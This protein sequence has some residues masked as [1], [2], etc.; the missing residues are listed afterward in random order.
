MTDVTQVIQ[1]DPASNECNQ[2]RTDE[3][4]C[5]V[6]PFIYLGKT[7]E[8]C[9]TVDYNNKL[10]CATTSNY[11]Q[12]K[13][14]GNCENA[15]TDENRF[16]PG[17]AYV[18]ECRKN[19]DYMLLY[20]KKSCKTCA[21]GRPSAC[22]D[23]N[24][25][26]PG[27]ASRGECEKNPN[28]MLVNCQ[29]SCK[30]C[31]GGDS[32]IGIEMLTALTALKTDGKNLAS[33]W[34]DN[35]KLCSSCSD[36]NG[37]TATRFQ[38]VAHGL[39]AAGQVAD[40]ISKF[41]DAMEVP[42]ALFQKLGAVGALFGAFS[43]MV[44]IIG[45]FGDSLEV[46]LLNKLLKTVNEGFDRMESRFDRVDDKLNRLVNQLH[47]DSFY[48]GVLPHVGKLQ[49][50]KINVEEYIQ[51]FS[52]C[53]DATNCAHL[54]QKRQDLERYDYV[55]LEESLNSI[56]R[57]FTGFI[58]QPPMCELMTKATE[59]DRLKV[60]EAGI[61]LYQHLIR[62]VADLLMVGALQGRGDA[63]MEKVK[64]T[65]IVKKIVAGMEKCDAN[66]ASTEWKNR[67]G[68]YNQPIWMDDM[69]TAIREYE[70][71]GTK[72]VAA[73]I[74][75][76]LSVKYFW[77]DW[78]VVVYTKMHGSD[79]H[80]RSY[81]G[82]EGVTTAD[83]RDKHGFDIL[84]SSLASTDPKNRFSGHVST[85][86]S[87][88][89][90]ANCCGPNPGKEWQPVAINSAKDVFNTLPSSVGEKCISGVVKGGEVAVQAPTDR[91]FFY[92][93]STSYSQGR[94]HL[95]LSPFHVFVLG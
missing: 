83:W 69:D 34:D 39:T 87:V 75:K 80:W 86:T 54:N 27:W 55:E 18:G 43:S 66:I 38:Q 46:Q 49:S 85:T 47:K 89:K 41:M 77:R 35:W 73:A 24:Q 90:E 68:D 57:G 8:G 95:S 25:H 23:Q 45:L 76:K 4:T 64:W 42:K 1:N 37:A 28:Y 65:G 91:K 62:G 63:D 59:V 16:C 56:H 51:G 48:E 2:R 3:D 30:I 52:H 12:D 15:C 40:G 14:W 74:Y 21:G 82:E 36:A 44:S 32:A 79:N 53:D 70:T 13:E 9:T 33:E 60:L 17:W 67:Q 50:L 31:G 72:L 10:W 88:Y 29:K 61:E 58:G 6:F 93:T 81:C 92:I 94:Y 78:L 19:P 22:T 26:C 5:C 71:A 7:Y 11:D 20:C 84:V